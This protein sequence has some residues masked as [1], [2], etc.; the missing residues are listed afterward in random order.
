MRVQVPDPPDPQVVGP[1]LR[2]VPLLA[3]GIRGVGPF[4][5]LTTSWMR[6]PDQLLRS[7]YVFLAS[8]FS[9]SRHASQLLKTAASFGPIATV[10]D[11]LAV[12]PGATADVIVRAAAELS[13]GCLT[14]PTSGLVSLTPSTNARTDRPGIALVPTISHINS[15]T[16]AEL[17]RRLGVEPGMRKDERIDALQSGLRNPA[18]IQ[19]VLSTLSADARIAFDLLM[20]RT[21][22][23]SVTDLGVDYYM[24][25]TNYPRYRRESNV[26]DDLMATGLIGVDSAEQTCW[27][28]LDV[29]LAMRG[30]L[31][32]D[33]SE[34]A[35]LTP[36]ALAEPG[37]TLPR[38]LVQ[39]D[40]LLDLWANEPAMALKTGGIAVKD[41]KRISKTLGISEA[42]ASLLVVLAISLR[43]IVSSPV[44]VTKRGRTMI[45]GYQ[46][47]A[48][49]ARGGWDRLDAHL[50]WAH[51]VQAWLS[52]PDASHDDYL[53]VRRTVAKVLLVRALQQLPLGTGI[54]E[55]DL[56][57]MLTHRHHGFGDVALHD[58]ITQLR[59][60]G[61]VPPTGP[62]GLSELGRVVMT[63]PTDVGALVTS[64]DDWFIVQA[65][66]TITAP[67]HLDLALTSMLESIA[68]I[69]SDG[70][71]R[72]YRL[73]DARISR[74][75]Q[76][77]T[78]TE[79][80]MAFLTEHSRVPI[81][82]N[83]ERFIDD[84][85]QRAGRLTLAT[86]GCYLVSTD[87]L[88][89]AEACAVK[90]AHLTII[91]PTVAVSPLSEDV[92]RT[93]LRNKG[94]V[95]TVTASLLSTQP[96][97]QLGAAITLP[98]LASVLI[99]S[100]DAIE[101][102]IRELTHRD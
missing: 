14:D 22:A 37:R 63:S 66:L 71:A 90:A 39:M 62:V 97:R 45:D 3:E 31:Y 47:H 26:V 76:T 69:E 27:V 60:L 67:A 61:V 8:E 33:W 56:G 29:V 41:I 43:L 1:A 102:L 23:V 85:V 53:T 9:I 57:V 79:Q 2:S 7:P 24:G 80:L 70:G 30:G 16:I 54:N 35:E 38:L 5:D 95:L 42:A 68:V 77:G 20:E 6:D 86:A 18:V 75:A 72:I 17:A 78:T 94:M 92:V 99:H 73:D 83:V 15:E 4:K 101:T 10:D 55:A 25:V 12:C 87:S 34:P 58:Y 82:Q 11:A 100:P 84:A 50:R 52:L 46:W 93:H 21:G 65:D 36:G 48:S 89:L 96:D 13:G 59:L 64:G 32:D 49:S 81:S 44:L 51:L 98:P 88:A 40:Q 91:A 19:R 74:S 28:W